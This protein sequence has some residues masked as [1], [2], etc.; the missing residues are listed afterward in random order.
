MAS[1]WKAVGKLED[2]K[3]QVMICSFGLSADPH[4]HERSKATPLSPGSVV[5]KGRQWSLNSSYATNPDYKLTNRKSAGQ[6]QRR[7]CFSAQIC[8]ETEALMLQWAFIV[9]IDTQEL[10][11]DSLFTSLNPTHSPKI[12]AMKIKRESGSDVFTPGIMGKHVFQF[13]LFFHSFFFFASGRFIACLVP[14]ELISNTPTYRSLFGSIF[15]PRIRLS[16]LSRSV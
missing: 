15:V 12:N 1:V 6:C 3:K 4:P 8:A 16:A 14:C 2:C 7:K 9:F 11:Y 5:T 13:L 10:L